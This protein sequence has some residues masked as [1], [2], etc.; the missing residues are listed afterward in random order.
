MR[1]FL[2]LALAACGG[3]KSPARP[4]DLGNCTPYDR[5]GKAY[6]L[7][8]RAGATPS[9]SAAAEAPPPTESQRVR[10]AELARD[11]AE[12]SAREAEKQAHEAAERVDKLSRDLED[13][14]KRLTGAVDSVIAAQTD[15]DRSAARARLEQLRK[16]KAEMEARIAAA[17]AAAEKAQRQKGVKIS[18]ECQDNPLAKGCS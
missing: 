15:A 2:V 12:A 1:Y 18:K 13:L 9:A 3:S 8:E 17:K 4:N 10:D 16:E 5:D 7:C 11:K 14:D 6:Y